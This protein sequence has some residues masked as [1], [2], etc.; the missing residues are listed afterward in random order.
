MRNCV[1][2]AKAPNSGGGPLPSFI[3]ETC[4]LTVYHNTKIWNAVPVMGTHWIIPCTVITSYQA[5]SLSTGY[6][7]SCAAESHV[8]RWLGFCRDCTLSVS[9]GSCHRSML[10]YQRQR[11]KRWRNNEVV[12]KVATKLSILQ[13]KLVRNQ[14]KTARVAVTE[15]HFN[16]SQKWQFTYLGRLSSYPALG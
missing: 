15:C 5:N 6:Q 2:S 4:N 9:A 16:I 13:N 11:T 7:H 10:C 8:F 3:T 14:P 1:F 12:Q